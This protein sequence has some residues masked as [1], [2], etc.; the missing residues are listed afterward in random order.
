MRPGLVGRP[1]QIK[2]ALVPCVLRP[3]P[4]AFPWHYA[5][6]KGFLSPRVSS[7]FRSDCMCV[8]PAAPR[9]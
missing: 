8:T 9:A 3:V 2:G 4:H 7:P 6:G 5:L 1:C